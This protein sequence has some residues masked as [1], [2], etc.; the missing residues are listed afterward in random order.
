MYKKEIEKL[1]EE[2]FEDNEVYSME[3]AFEAG[4]NLIS[5]DYKETKKENEYLEKE[6]RKTLNNVEY[7]LEV[8]EHFKVRCEKLLLIA[9]KYRNELKICNDQNTKL[10]QQ[11][12]DIQSNKDKKS[13][14][15]NKQAENIR[16][17]FKPGRKY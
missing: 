2:W 15:A 14:L 6:L 1:F 12:K 7:C 10:K 9:K 8:I 17:K 4:Y 16:N 3:E 13:L 5:K 11:I